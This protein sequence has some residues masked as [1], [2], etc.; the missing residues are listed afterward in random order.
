[1]SSADE[2]TASH[3]RRTLCPSDLKWLEVISPRPFPRPNQ[4]FTLTE[5]VVSIVVAGILAASVVPRFTGENG[6]EGRGFRDETAAAL[7]YAQKSAIASRR[8]VCVAFTASAVS[9]RVASAA[10][11]ADCTAGSALVGPGGNTLSVSA[12][13]GATFSPTPAALTFNAAGQPN[14]GVSIGVS[15]LPGSLAIIVEAETGY[16][17]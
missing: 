4:G 12:T 1:M 7:R 16:V 9:A 5:L 10:G 11:A 17:H 6:F 3:P 8:L 13:G 2:F 14:A 15:G